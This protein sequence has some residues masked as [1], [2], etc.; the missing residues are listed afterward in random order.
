MLDFWNAEIMVVF[1][2]WSLTK[3]ELNSQS[4]GNRRL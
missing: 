3:I 2:L 1:I 4:I